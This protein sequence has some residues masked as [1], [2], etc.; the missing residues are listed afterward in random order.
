MINGGGVGVAEATPA[1]H[2]DP[3]KSRNTSRDPAA[4]N[5]PAFNSTAP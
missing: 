5:A 1:A 4:L 2:V 3:L